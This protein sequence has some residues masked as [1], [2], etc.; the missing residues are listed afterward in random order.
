[1]GIVGD[2]T[3]SSIK[4][5]PYPDTA[6]GGL[7]KDVERSPPTRAT[8]SGT[9]GPASN[10]DFVPNRPEPRVTSA[11]ISIKSGVM[12]TDFTAIGTPARVHASERLLLG[13]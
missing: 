6:Y 10:G 1:M 12:K 7:T 4:T 9:G 2:S 11:A 13:V 5:R 8:K 3:D